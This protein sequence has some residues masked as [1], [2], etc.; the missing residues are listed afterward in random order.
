MQQHERF[1]II[2]KLMNRGVELKDKLVRA[3]FS[4]RDVSQA[5]AQAWYDT[6]MEWYAKTLPDLDADLHARF[7]AAHLGTA[8][9]LGTQRLLE[10]LIQARDPD[11]EIAA[12]AYELIRP[13]FWHVPLE[14]LLYVH[15]ETL[16][17]ARRRAFPATHAIPEDV[18]EAVAASCWRSG[19]HTIDHLFINSG[20][21]PQ[22]WLQP[23]R[24]YKL[25]SEQRVHG[26]LDAIQV[27]APEREITIVRAV[28]K[29]M[30][31]DQ[32][33][34][35]T[36]RAE[37]QAFLAQTQP[38]PTFRTT[39]V[40]AA[41]TAAHAGPTLSCFIS[42]SSRDEALAQRLYIDLQA[43]GVSCWIARHDLEIGIPI[44]HGIDEALSRQDAV[45]LI[46]S[47][48]S[49]MS[50]WV[51]HEVALALT[52]ER[53]EHRNLLFPLRVDNAV[54][55]AASGWAAQLRSRHIGDFRDWKQYDEYQQGFRQL[56]RALKRAKDDQGSHG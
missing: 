12:P 44:V 24:L 13:Q 29:K 55:E 34:T 31:P 48:A 35:E 3:R 16:E 49:V 26:W 47:E 5:D 54:L 7:S 53:T 36:Q 41:G 6:Y 21:E 43:A 22:W 25:Q 2:N 39:A 52:R 37:I 19:N 46:L 23:V 28:C 11:P 9:H 1:L 10:L 8:D 32:R 17:T 14:D 40:P 20:C 51:E 56:L 15:L 42:Y 45:V 30:L 27:Y 18:R 4:I 50:G 33:L 38:G